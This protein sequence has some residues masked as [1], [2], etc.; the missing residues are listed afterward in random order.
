[1]VFSAVNSVSSVF[2]LSIPAKSSS[3]PATSVPIYARYQATK[4]NTTTNTWTDSGNNA[5]TLPSSQ[6]TNTGLSLVSGTGN[7]ASKSFNVLQGTNSSRIQFTTAQIPQYTLFH[8]TRYT[9]G[10]NNRVVA[11]STN[12]WLSG[13]HGNTSGVAHYDNWITQTST[14]VF[15]NNW[16]ISTSS[17]NNIYRGNGVSYATGTG[18]TSYLPAF[19]I[20]VDPYNQQS[21][22]QVADVLIYNS[23]LSLADIKIVE[24]F[25][26]DL[27][28]ITIT[29]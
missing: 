4:Y 16:L 27:Y 18:A 8:V 13:F 26:A 23:Y 7:G 11:S 12:N 29:R 24:A 17:N 28:G 21:T 14:N 9:G 2:G 15:G 3:G 19:G 20:N 10:S 5:Y 1:M 22:F 6:I 25:L